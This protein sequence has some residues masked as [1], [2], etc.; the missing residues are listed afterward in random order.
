MKGKNNWLELGI[1]IIV[2]GGLS[3]ITL[4]QFNLAKAKSRDMDRK[5]NLHEISKV[6]RL[7]YKDYKKLPEE[8]LVNSLWGKQWMDG[9]YVY[10]KVVPSENYLL[11]K[12]YCYQIS[13]DGKSF[14]LFA[15]L[16]N[17]GD[18]DCSKNLWQ[19]GG[20][21]YCYKDVLEAEEII[22]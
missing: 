18:V 2:L 21:D 3:W 19:C 1:I 13:S 15:D 9:S 17:K 5:S 6:I 14:Y 12:E 7:Y 11:N 10:M 4:G 16:E 22:N 8:K 20:V